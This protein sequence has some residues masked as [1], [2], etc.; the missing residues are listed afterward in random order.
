MSMWFDLIRTSVAILAQASLPSPL[1]FAY[2]LHGFPAPIVG[3]LEVVVSAIF[4]RLAA[5]GGSRHVIAAAT[6]AALHTVLE[7]M[8]DPCGG[9]TSMQIL[10]EVAKEVEPIAAALAVQRLV[11]TIAGKPL[12]NGRLANQQL[13]L[14]HPEVAEE[15]RALN[16]ISN[17]AK[18]GR[19]RGGRRSRAAAPADDGPT[20]SDGSDVGTVF[21]FELPA[22]QPEDAAAATSSGNCRAFSAGQRGGGLAYGPTTIGGLEYQRSHRVQ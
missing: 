10:V 15:V 18:H 11:G 2:G 7:L 22:A 16:W 9:L 13:R 5:G 8:G 6:A 21:G 4:P 1:L 14:T 12:H 17:L 19:T 3:H 20:T